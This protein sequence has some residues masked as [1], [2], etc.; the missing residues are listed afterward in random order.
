[1]RDK[2]EGKNLFLETFTD[3]QIFPQMPESN[4]GGAEIPVPA[5]SC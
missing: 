3:P 4:K 2:Q 5:S 1:M